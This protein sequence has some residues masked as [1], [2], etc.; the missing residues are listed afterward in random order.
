M[1]KMIL[2][3]LAFAIS[4]PATL[5][6]QDDIY[7]I[8][9]RKYLRRVFTQRHP[10]MS[11]RQMQMMIG[12]SIHTTVVVLLQQLRLTTVMHLRITPTRLSQSMMTRP[13]IRIQ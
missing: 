5:F 6:A 3:T 2:L 12:M 13:Y 9:R 7:M 8:M 4:I 11:G 1:R 10:V